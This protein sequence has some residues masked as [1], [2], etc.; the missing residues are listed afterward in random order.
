MCIRIDFLTV[1]FQINDVLIL[2]VIG[3]I[4]NRKQT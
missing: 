2:G 3:G 1:Y 4:N